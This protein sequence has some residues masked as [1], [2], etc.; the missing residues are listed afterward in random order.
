MPEVS[1]LPGQVWEGVGR[2]AALVQILHLETLLSQCPLLVSGRPYQR[3]YGRRLE[4]GTFAR[5]CQK[6]LTGSG[7]EIAAQRNFLVTV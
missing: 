3:Q 7:P 4:N 6:I 1:T 2:K 5:V